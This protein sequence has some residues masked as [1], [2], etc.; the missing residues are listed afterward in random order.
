MKTP[1]QLKRANLVGT[2]IRLL[3]ELRGWTQHGFAKKLRAAGQPVSRD[4]VARWELCESAINDTRLPGISTV[5]R[6]SIVDLFPPK[7]RG[8]AR[9]F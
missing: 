9:T 5:L 3:R 6:V 7:Q 1:R 2:R 8:R 4:M